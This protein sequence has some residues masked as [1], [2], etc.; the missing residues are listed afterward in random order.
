M[1]TVYDVP[2]EPLIRK[3]AE[4]LKGE[5]AV[6]PPA[7][8]PFVTTGIHAEKPPVESDWWHVRAAA[9]LRKVYVMGPIGTERLRAEFGGS[10]D[11]GAKPNRAKKGSGSVVR[12][13][14]QQL[15]K[16]GLV[17]AVKGE[18]RVVSAKGRSLLDNTAHEV[19][20]GLEVAGLEKY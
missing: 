2:A 9:V 10:R 6:Q 1:T 14:L 13:S 17:Q 18:G 19:R 4:K 20:Q 16:A 8:A 7:W 11:R 15:E 3:A 12:E 5:K